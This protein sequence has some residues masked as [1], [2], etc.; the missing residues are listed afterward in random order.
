MGSLNPFDPFLATHTAHTRKTDSGRVI[1]PEQR[2][3]RED[4]LR[5]MTTDAAW[6][7]FDEGRRGSLEAGKLPISRFSRTTCWRAR[8]SGSRT[9]GRW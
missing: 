5:A 6:L 8:K 1:R 2:I 7:S 3:S 4:A 9:F